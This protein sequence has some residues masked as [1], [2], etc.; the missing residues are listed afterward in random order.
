MDVLGSWFLTV[1]T[2]TVDGKK[3]LKKRKKK[4]KT[5]KM[6]NRTGRRRRSLDVHD[7]LGQHL[8]VVLLH[9]QR[10]QRD[11]LVPGAQ[12]DQLQR[13]VAAA[14]VAGGLDGQLREEL[15]GHGVH[16]VGVVAR[17]QSLHRA[18]RHRPLRPATG[19]SVIQVLG[20]AIT[21]SVLTGGGKQGGKGAGEE[22][23]GGG[24]QT[25][26]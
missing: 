18:L 12:R 24:R 20:H 8:R 26:R 2:V 23:G 25:Y 11:G 21:R 6:K 3:T 14:T 4:K 9:G 7:E 5:K 17:D 15:V 22:G 13:R 10:R 1:C 19:N 16:Q